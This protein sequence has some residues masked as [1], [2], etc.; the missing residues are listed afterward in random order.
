M[1]KSSLENV[2]WISW[3]TQFFKRYFHTLIH[4]IAVASKEN[5]DI[6]TVFRGRTLSS[7]PTNIYLF[8]VFRYIRPIHADW[9]TFLYLLLLLLLLLLI[10]IIL[11]R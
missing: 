8:R 3:R 2:T 5:V 4:T 6:E 11:C 9:L 1:P 7:I 10:I